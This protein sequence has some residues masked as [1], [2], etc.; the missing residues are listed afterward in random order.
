MRSGR[1]CQ[2]VDIPLA[3]RNVSTAA[4]PKRYGA[5]W[6]CPATSCMLT[7][8]VELAGALVIAGT[9]HARHQRQEWRAVKYL[10]AARTCKRVRE[11]EFEFAWGLYYSCAHGVSRK[12]ATL[13][14]ASCVLQGAQW[15][16][17]PLGRQQADAPDSTTARPGHDD[18][19]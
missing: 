9:Q 5:V 13:A 2:A 14:C 4:P 7:H 12:P 1:G 8:G 17:A 15:A 6:S 3:Q 18:V 11:H 16:G 10:G 19:S